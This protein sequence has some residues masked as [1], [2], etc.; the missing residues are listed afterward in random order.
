MDTAGEL[1]GVVGLLG[2]FGVLM[3][4]VLRS[5]CRNHDTAERLCRECHRDPK[6]TSP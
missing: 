1:I 3:L 6:E 4:S 2:L 5:T